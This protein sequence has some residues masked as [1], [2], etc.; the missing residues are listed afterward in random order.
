MNVPAEALRAHPNCLQAGTRIAE[1]QI[2]GLVGEGGFGI[3]YAARDT[4]LQR[5]LALKEFM[6]VALAGRVDGVR[7]AV[8]SADSQA[9]FD[10]GLQGFIKEARL[11]ARFT[12]PALVKVYRFLEANGTGYM[13]MRLYAGETLAQPLARGEKFDEESMARIMLP[14]FS[15]LE[16]LHAEQVFHRDIAPDNIMLAQSGSVLLDFGS[17]RHVIGEDQALTA[18]LKPS[19][20]P[21]EQ[22]AAD[23]SMR[24]GAWTDVY[25]MGS[26]LY[27]M[28]TGR[29]PVQAV[30]RLMDDPLRTVAEITGH[31]FSAAFC[32]AV[33]KAMAVR[34]EDRI[35][36]MQELRDMLGWNALPARSSASANKHAWQPSPARR[37]PPAAANV[38]MP[39][40]SA[41][42]LARGLVEGQRLLRLLVEQPAMALAAAALL[43]GLSAL[44][45]WWW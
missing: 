36:S 8:R 42:P 9:K 32:Q 26:V 16:M 2:T 1:F 39:T 37:A 15:A 44:V 11:L 7:V 13:A 43:A 6:P 29:A 12:H 30:S 25:A 24:Q 5:D 33:T 34:V 40:V 45:V 41:T 21:V 18:V 22:Y 38:P 27:H 10:A 28:A 3:V 35:Q 4:A 20:S 14:V 17:A 31:T 19:Y 23:G